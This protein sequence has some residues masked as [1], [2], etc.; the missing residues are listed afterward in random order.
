MNRKIRYVLLALLILFIFTLSS[1][2]S[3]L[4]SQD[5]S[6]RANTQSLQLPGLKDRITVR[7]DERGV[8]YIEAANDADLYFAQGY[9]TASDRLWQ[10]DLMR[11]TARGEL[12]EVLTAGP[13]NL[14]V[15]QDKQHRTMGFAQE[16]EA[17]LVQ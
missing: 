14:A 17:E 16:V 12:A 1:D 3:S 7:R 11:R 5:A 6:G 13:N 10:M 2:S 4:A 8:P 15:E 9:V